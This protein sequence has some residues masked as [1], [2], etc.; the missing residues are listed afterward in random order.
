MRLRIR[1]TE[2]AC[3]IDMTPMIDMVFQLLVF[4]I[5]SLKIST[6]EGDFNIKMPLNAPSEG[7]PDDRQLPPIKIQ[8]KADASGNLTN[9]QM[10]DRA[11]GTQ[12]DVLRGQIM[13]LVGDDRGPGS[14]AETAEVELDCDYHL[15]YEFVIKAITAVSGY[16][17]GDGRVVKLIEKIK[18]S[19]PQKPGE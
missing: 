11:L 14:V 18:F 9:I 7:V 17:T 6:P 13:G 4:F 1:N 2:H 16:V 15:R 10:N 12:F 8:L 3:K 19:A 5:M